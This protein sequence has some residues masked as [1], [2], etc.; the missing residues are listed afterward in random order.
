MRSVRSMRSS[1]PIRFMYLDPLLLLLVILL[2]SVAVALA[3]AVCGI[4]SLTPRFS[5]VLVALRWRKT[6]S[7]VPRSLKKLLKQ[8][9]APLSFLTLK[10]GVNEKHPAA[11]SKTV[12][13]IP[14]TLVAAEV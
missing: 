9:V 5:G 14:G 12:E 1:P 4:L 8:S 2:D 3:W 11:T 10:R 13:K 7:P 6:V